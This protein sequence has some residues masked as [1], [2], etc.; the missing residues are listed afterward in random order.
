MEAESLVIDGQV[1]YFKSSETMDELSDSSI[2]V[3]VTSPPYNRNK[4]YSSDDNEAHDDNLPEIEYLSFLRRVWS[5][6]LRVASEK[7]VFFLNI[8]DS[9]NDQGISEKVA[10]SAVEAGWARVQDIAW[11]KSIYGKGH[12]TPTG[13]NKRFNNV[14]E[15]VFMLVKDPGSYEINP[16]NIGIPYADKSNIGRYGDEDLRDPG[17]AWH[18]WYETTTGA[19]VKKGHDAPYPIGLPY[20]CIKVVPGASTV[21]DPF[22]GTGTTLAAAACL[23]L[24]GVGYEKYPRRELIKATILAGRDYVPKPTVLIPHMETSIALLLKFLGRTN[25]N[26][27]IPQ[28]KRERDQYLVLKDTLEKLGTGEEFIARLGRAIDAFDA[29]ENGVVTA[30]RPEK[31]GSSNLD[32]FIGT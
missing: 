15:H 24:K 30:S 25:P 22:A 9:A 23:G 5:E 16:K 29:E 3:I 27:G 13:N 14:W 10:G 19:T 11:V 31:K 32:R 17:N 12:Y 28:S 21:L 6:N 2:D 26:I 20:T 4:H 7:A 18:V 1:V 8:G